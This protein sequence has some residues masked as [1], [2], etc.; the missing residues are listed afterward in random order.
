MDDTTAAS[1]G[2]GKE[3]FLEIVANNI[4]QIFVFLVVFLAII[5]GWCYLRYRRQQSENTQ[6]NHKTLQ[7]DIEK[8]I[9]NQQELEEIEKL[10]K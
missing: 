3:S 6:S 8:Q 7:A 10:E 1:S 5:I 2:S 4:G 9:K